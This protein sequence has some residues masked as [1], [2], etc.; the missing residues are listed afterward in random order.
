MKKQGQITSPNVASQFNVGDRVAL[1]NDFLRN[2]QIQRRGVIATIQ[3]RPKG[4]P[5]GGS[6]GLVRF[7]VVALDNL[8]VS[9]PSTID[10]EFAQLLMIDPPE[11]VY[12][13]CD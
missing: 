6:T 12:H 11:S 2:P 1:I 8:L 10:H 7:I 5:N 4:A 9:R 3:D 13:Y